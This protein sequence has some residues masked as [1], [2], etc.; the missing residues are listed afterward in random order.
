MG[1]VRRARSGVMTED[2]SASFSRQTGA[3]R[4][5]ARCAVEDQPGRQAEREFQVMWGDKSKVAVTYV[6][7]SIVTRDPRTGTK[8]KLLKDVPG[9]EEKSKV[10]LPGELWLSYADGKMEASLLEGKPRS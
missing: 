10:Y 2:E 5:I 3:L 9:F 8:V 7:V 4:T 1:A 6:E